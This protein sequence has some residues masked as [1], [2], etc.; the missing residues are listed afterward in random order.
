MKFLKHTGEYVELLKELLDGALGAK[1]DKKDKAEVIFPS[2]IEELNPSH[3]QV[4]IDGL[5]FTDSYRSN[6]GRQTYHLSVDVFI[7]VPSNLTDPEL[8]SST[9]A[10]Y[11]LKELEGQR[12]GYKSETIENPT[13]PNA[14]PLPWTNDGAGHHVSFAQIIRTGEVPDAP[15]IK[16]SIE[17]N[18]RT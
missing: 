5:E 1:S 14:V 6:D 9:M 3:P 17:I 11:V 12:F 15:L 7:K 13:S 16:P 2:Q 8:I 4:I 10:G 18:R